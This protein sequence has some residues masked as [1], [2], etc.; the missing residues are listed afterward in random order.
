MPKQLSLLDTIKAGPKTNMIMRKLVII[1]IIAIL[2]SLSIAQN[3][4]DKYE[5]MKDVSSMVITS[6][7]FKLLSKIDFESSD[8]ETQQYI[9]LV[10]NIE[11]IKVFAT[12]NTEVGKKMKQD[13]DAYL[14]KSTLD[15]LMRVNSEGK[16]I[17]FYSKPGKN[18]DYVSEL[19][20]FLD[21]M[22]EDGGPKT[23]VLTI[24]GNIDLK[25]VSKLADDLNIP[26]G[27]ELKKVEKR[28]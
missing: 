18:E 19:F 16:N 9:N 22:D 5:N 23:V 10:E 4:F 25:Q 27:K 21:G 13:V 7:M 2:P 8:A 20:M 24:T 26:G 14:K 3:G 12:E 11:N 17:K 6:K 15:E 28:N 1:M